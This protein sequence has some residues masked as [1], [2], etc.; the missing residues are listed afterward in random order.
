MH[1]QVKFSHLPSVRSVKMDWPARRGD[2]YHA[3]QGISGNF[4]RYE[5]CYFVNTIIQDPEGVII[6]RSSGSPVS[7]IKTRVNVKENSPAPMLAE[8]HGCGHLTRTEK[9][10]LLQLKL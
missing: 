2:I 8:G 1:V 10:S 7:F 4:L 3:H 6:C 9:S 5:A